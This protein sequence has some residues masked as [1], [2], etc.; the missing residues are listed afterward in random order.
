MSWLNEA[1]LEVYDLDHAVDMTTKKRLTM[2]FSKMLF[3]IE[4]YVYTREAYGAH[5]PPFALAIPI[6]PIVKEQPPTQ[7]F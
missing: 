6:A 2:D 7:E 5:D 4:K 3:R 1:A